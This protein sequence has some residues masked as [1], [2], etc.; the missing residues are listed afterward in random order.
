MFACATPTFPLPQTALTP[1]VTQDLQDGVQ[2]TVRPVN[3]LTFAHFPTLSLRLRW[4]ES[5]IFWRL[6]PESTP[7]RDLVL[8]LVPLPSLAITIANHGTAAVSLRSAHVTVDD[9]QGHA[10]A[11]VAKSDELIGPVLERLLSNTPE[12]WQRVQALG[13]PATWPPYLGPDWWTAPIE[14][15]RD[16]TRRVPLFGTDVVIAPGET[17][18]LALVAKVGAA[19]PEALASLMRG[20]LRV[21]LDGVRA[22]ERELLPQTFTFQ[23]AAP[24]RSTPC[25]IE[26]GPFWYNRPLTAY[27]ADGRRVLRSDVEAL[28]L[29]TRDS[30]AA[31]ARSRRLRIAGYTLIAA[32]V[33]GSVGVVAGIAGTGDHRDA[34]AGLSGLAVSGVGAALNYFAQK[35]FSE[36]LRSYNAY[37]AATGACRTPL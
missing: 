9:G 11:V 23:V 8:P 26:G 16:E 31:A 32:S 19:S 35:S 30:H 18:T 17:R 12:L 34:P 36:G 28:L 14:V 29:A 27:W 33:F 1:T 24:E 3:Q 13:P 10:W 5:P 37:A 4:H 20:D 7:D 2:I 6:L 21:Q 15:L 25:V 22:G